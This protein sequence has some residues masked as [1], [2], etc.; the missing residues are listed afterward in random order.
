MGSCTGDGCSLGIGYGSTLGGGTTLVG[1]WCSLGIECG[2]TLGGGTNLGGDT[3][4]VVGT[5][6]GGGAAIRVADGGTSAVLVFQW[7]KRSWSLDIADS[8]S[9]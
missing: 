8:C 1:D 7:E 9:W 5:T 2:S 6:L 3:T 4:L